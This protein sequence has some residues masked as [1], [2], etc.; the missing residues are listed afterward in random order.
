MMAVLIVA[1]VLAYEFL[2]VMGCKM[3]R[4]N[5]LV[6]GCQGAKSW[7]VPAFLLRLIVLTLLVSIGIFIQF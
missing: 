3:T 4:K 6:G 7:Y 2:T 5:C 1:G